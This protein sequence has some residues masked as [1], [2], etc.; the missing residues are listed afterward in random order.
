MASI[1]GTRVNRYD[2]RIKEPHYAILTFGS[3][4]IPGDE[5]SRTN[6]GHGYPASTEYHVEYEAF[7]EEQKEIWEKK[8]EF[9]EKQNTPYQALRVNPVTVKTIVEVDIDA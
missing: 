4:Y 5:R 2:E 6:P 3:T 9:Y 8:I 7:T 1:Y